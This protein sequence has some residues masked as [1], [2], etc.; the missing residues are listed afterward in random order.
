M[1]SSGLKWLLAKVRLCQAGVENG[2]GQK[3]RFCVSQQIPRKFARNLRKC[4]GECVC[5]EQH[6]PFLSV[7]WQSTGFYNEVLAGKV[8]SFAKAALVFALL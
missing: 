4:F 3:V 2:N 8:L 6:A 1:T 5:A 7:N